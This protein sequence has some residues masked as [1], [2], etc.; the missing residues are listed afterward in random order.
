MGDPR[1][2]RKKWVGPKHPWRLDIL[3]EEVELLGRYGLRD[4]R[5]LWKAKTMLR[6]FRHRA[7]ELLGNPDEKKEKELIAK[8]VGLGVLGEGATLDDVLGLTVDKLLERRLQTVVYKKGL[9]KTLHQA[10][11]YITHGHIAIGDR[12]V[13]VPSYI[14]R[15]KEEALVDYTPLSPLSRR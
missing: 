15:A 8:L 4:K 7:R 9:A 14:V 2:R 6:K 12:V 5:E 10:R 13:S 3:K 11:Q 1:R